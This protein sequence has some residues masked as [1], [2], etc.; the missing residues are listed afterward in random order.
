MAGIHQP[1][2]HRR[3]AG[4]GRLGGAGVLGDHVPGAPPR[5]VVQ[6]AR[7][8][9]ELLHGHVSQRGHAEKSRG[10][11]ALCPALVVLGVDQAATG[12]GVEDDHH[13]LGR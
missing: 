6:V 11:L 8:R 12:R 1:A 7:P 10:L 3:V 4:P 5:Q 2:K 9:L 13:R